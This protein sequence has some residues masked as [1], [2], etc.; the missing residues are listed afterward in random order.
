MERLGGFENAVCT[1]RISIV[2][3]GRRTALEHHSSKGGGGGAGT[4]RGNGDAQ[5]RRNPISS[6][7]NDKS[8]ILATLAK[9]N[10]AIHANNDVHESQPKSHSK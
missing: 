7:M 6:R 9:N 1:H 5:Q 2:H 10:Y 8:S 4:L 3:L